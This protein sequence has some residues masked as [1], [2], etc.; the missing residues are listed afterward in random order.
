MDSTAIA[1][2]LETLRNLHADVLM[3][4][5]AVREPFAVASW[6]SRRIHRLVTLLG[7]IR[8]EETALLNR[9]KA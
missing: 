4:R 9:T 2:R 3:R 6:L 7:K 8:D 5:R 1:A